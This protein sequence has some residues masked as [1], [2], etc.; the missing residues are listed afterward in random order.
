VRIPTKWIKVSG[1]AWILIPG[2]LN[3][4][5]GKAKSHQIN[6]I[7]SPI[8]LSTR[9]GMNIQQRPEWLFTSPGICSQM[10]ADDPRWASRTSRIFRASWFSTNGFCR[11]GA[12]CFTP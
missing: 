7:P 6:V 3:K 2:F 1:A 8:A 4:T 11:N 9:A 10:V 12:P 5:G